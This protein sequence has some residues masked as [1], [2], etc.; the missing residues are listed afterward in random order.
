MQ[1]GREGPT[2]LIQL[3]GGLRNP[4]RTVTPTGTTTIHMAGGT[5]CIDAP[6][7]SLLAM[8]RTFPYHQREMAS[9]TPHVSKPHDYVNHMFMRP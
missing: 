6:D 8:Y 7:T 5:A 3:R 1:L 2:V 4:D 9:V